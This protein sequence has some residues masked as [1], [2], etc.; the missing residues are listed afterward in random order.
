MLSLPSKPGPVLDNYLD[1]QPPSSEP[2]VALLVQRVLNNAGALPRQEQCRGP[3]V[4]PRIPTTRCQPLGFTS[5]KLPGD[6]QCAFN[7]SPG[8]TNTCWKARTTR[9]LLCLWRAHGTLPA[10]GTRSDPAPSPLP[11]Q[12]Q[13]LWP[14]F[15]SEPRFHHLCHHKL[16]FQHCLTGDQSAE[17][18]RGPQPPC[19]AEHEEASAQ[20]S[21]L[22]SEESASG[23]SPSR[24]SG[25]G[26]SP[27]LCLPK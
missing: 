8:A 25:L 3:A 12:L 1:Q 18:G 6:A 15:S 14:S 17:H 23:S 9:A 27:S 5:C 4:Q 20:P 24:Q 7:P 19:A 2:Q 13:G 11:R 16:C 21:S 22:P 26:F 10:P